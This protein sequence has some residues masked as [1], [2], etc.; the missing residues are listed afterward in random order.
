MIKY[1][2]K[3]GKVTN[4]N[5]QNALYVPELEENLLSVNQLIKKDFE[6]HFNKNGCQITLNGKTV[7]DGTLI[8]KLYKI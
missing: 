1:R 8:G 7:V 2:D 5:I 6:L 3:S 4:L